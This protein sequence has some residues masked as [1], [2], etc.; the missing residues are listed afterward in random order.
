ME[1]IPM[2]QT[3]AA[4]RRRYDHPSAWRGADLRDRDDWIIRL[5]AADNA[6]L[7]AALAVARSRGARI[8]SLGAADFPLPSLGARLQ[9]M[10]GEVIDGRGFALV[11]GFDI[12]AMSR[13]DVALAY[14][15]VGAWLGTGL[16]QNA[17]GDLLGHVTDLGVDFKQNNNARGYQ[18]RMTLPF[19]N[20][21]LDIV[22]LLCLQTARRGGLSRIASSTAVHNAILERRPDLLEVAY[23]PFCIDRR[24]E[25][26]AGK[27]PFY[28]GAIFETVGE[29]LF[30]RYNRTYFTTSQRFPEADRLTPQQVELM[31]L[32]D[33]IC[34]EPD[35]HLDMQLE[36][37]DMQFVCNYTT[38]H[39]RTEYED[40]PEKDRRRYLLRLW[41]DT[42][43]VPRL[44]PSWAERFE[45]MR[46]WMHDPKPPIFDL[47][48][49][50]AELAH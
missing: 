45:D 40:W 19:H 36:R 27:P 47:S 18:T 24:G 30:C 33:A 34:A 28:R 44:P 43:R 5:D 22:G 15:G 13:E 2:T 8:P 9:A 17:Q 10:C 49:R 16:A 21:A 32:V 12:S 41:L 4:A 1:E 38:L 6:E 35:Q 14:W 50:H 37:G 7:Q 42:G 31:D 3:P 20:D 29:R 46:L 48:N 25:A 11:R 39:S 23:Q 26:P